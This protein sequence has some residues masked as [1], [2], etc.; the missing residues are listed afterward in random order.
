MATILVKE[1]RHLS[2]V[3]LS[4]ILKRDVSSLSHCLRRLSVRLQYDRHLKA[5]IREAREAVGQTA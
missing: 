5:K 4:R 2:L 3:G 1:Q